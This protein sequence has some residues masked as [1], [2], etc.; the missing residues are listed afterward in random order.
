[1]W[2]WRLWLFRTLSLSHWGGRQTFS[3]VSRMCT[4]VHGSDIGIVQREEKVGEG[5]ICVV[6]WHSSGLLIYAEDRVQEIF[7]SP[8]ENFHWLSYLATESPCQSR[9]SSGPIKKYHKLSADTQKKCPVIHIDYI[10]AIIIIV[11]MMMLVSASFIQIDT[12][13]I[14]FIGMVSN[15]KH[16]DWRRK[17]RM[18]AQSHDRVTCIKLSRLKIYVSW[19]EKCNI[20]TSK[21][22]R[23]GIE[24]GILLCREN[25]WQQRCF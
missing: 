17:V 2:F 23:K 8:P 21:S 14:V 20:L 4:K 13:H 22:G 3:N 25:Y 7:P 1:M 19:I 5:K 11:V 6:W 10:R 24:N 9:L 12:N 18:A 16:C 15:P